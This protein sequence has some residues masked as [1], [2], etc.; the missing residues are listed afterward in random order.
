MIIQITDENPA[1]NAT[2]AH[3]DLLSHGKEYFKL[4]TN[5]VFS[6][7]LMAT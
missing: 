1:A 6:H 3:H 2:L 5:D 7:I 4:K